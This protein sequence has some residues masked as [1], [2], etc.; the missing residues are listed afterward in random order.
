MA[1]E[2]VTDIHN[3]VT[4]YRAHSSFQVARPSSALEERRDRRYG[5]SES[6]SLCR[7]VA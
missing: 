6:H 5:Q 1:A 2:M 4:R 7:L 3:T